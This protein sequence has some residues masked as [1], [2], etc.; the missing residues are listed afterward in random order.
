METKKNNNVNG[1][2][3][4]VKENYGI[5][6]IKIEMGIFHAHELKSMAFYTRHLVNDL[7]HID[8]RKYPELSN[9]VIALCNFIDKITKEIPSKQNVHEDLFIE[10]EIPK[11]LA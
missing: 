10:E 7:E 11:E 9:N 6:G 8:I 1:L 4:T 2:N 3:I 5:T